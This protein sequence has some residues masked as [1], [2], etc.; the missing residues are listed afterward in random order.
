MAGGVK[1]EVAFDDGTLVE[2]PTWTDI[3]ENESLVT[4][5]Q[6]DRGRQ[7]ELD[8]TDIGRATV[9]I[10]DREGILDPTNS[11]SP[12]FSSID[13][14]LQIRLSVR[15]P[16]ADAYQV[17]YRGYIDETDYV[18]DPSQQV[19]KLAMSLVD[20][21]QL[22][23]QIQMQPDGSFGDTP[24]AASAGNIFF[25]NANV[26]DRMIQALGN[27]GWPTGLQVIFSG[28]VAMPESVY[29]PQDNVLEVLQ[30]GADAEFP[31]LGNLYVSRDGKVTFHGRQAKFDPVTVSAGAGGAW[32]FMTWDTGDGAAIAASV[33]PLAQIREFAFN[34]GLSRVINYASASP[35]GILPADLSGQL[36]QDLTSIGLRGFRTWSKENLLVD[37]GITT[38]NNAN[39][40]CKLYATYYVDNYAAPKNRV[41]N[42]AF[43]SI[44][45]DDDRAAATWGLLCGAEI[46][47]LL[48]VTVGSPGGGGFDIEPFFVE[49]IHYEVSP[50]NGD[51]AMVTL[52]P[53]L[54]PQSLFDTNPFA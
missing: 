8:V 28:N 21:M 50:L 7:Y 42:I 11:A 49:G 35:D 51:Y 45:P 34:R 12:Y 6:I 13:K 14:L 33:D 20:A 36:V 2:S 47:D 48:N 26:D 41:T 32:P 18:F 4:S 29:S 27:S 39:D 37:S 53:D 54:S 46:S 24:P 3:S 19:N 23:S 25:D 10:N 52:R 22:L 31:G 5:F 17:L 38:G 30:N 1:V 15:D 16:V 43:K 44:H 40:E 9:Q